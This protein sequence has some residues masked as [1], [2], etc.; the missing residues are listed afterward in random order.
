MISVQRGQLIKYLWLSKSC[1]ST[2]Y[3]FK[4]NSLRGG[5]RPVAGWH[6][7]VT[8]RWSHSAP[9]ALPSRTAAPPPPGRTGVSSRV[10]TGRNWPEFTNSLFSE[11]APAGPVSRPVRTRPEHCSSCSSSGAQADW[12]GAGRALGGRWEGAAGPDSC[13]QRR[14]A[15]ETSPTP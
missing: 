1:S 10:S 12:E 5:N 3:N 2:Q 6:P 9:S 4:Q 8:Q 11:R 15:S 13:S 7:V 14:P